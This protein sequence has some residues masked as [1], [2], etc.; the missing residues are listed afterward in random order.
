M[1]LAWKKSEN[2]SSTQT[3]IQYILRCCSN[4]FLAGLFRRLSTVVFVILHGLVYCYVC[5]RVLLFLLSCSVTLALVF[6]YVC[7]RC[8]PMFAL[9]FCYVCARCSVTLA[10]VF[11]YVCSRCPPMFA[12]VFCC[13]CALFPRK[14][15]GFAVFC[16]L[17]K[18]LFCKKLHLFCKH[19]ICS[20]KKNTF[21]LV[22]KIYMCS[23]Q[24][25][26]CS[27]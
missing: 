21:V 9:V 27:V 22:K 26:I 1:F 8:P 6:C 23:L 19:Y 24:K 15:V 25:I 4:T 10:L 13:F 20:V 17:I 11:C 2:E 18:H 16:K 7:S 12:P 14:N 5:S 3:L